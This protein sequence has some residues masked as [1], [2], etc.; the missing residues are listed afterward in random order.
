[1]AK[2]IIP[3]IM[4]FIII[5]SFFSDSHA[6]ES[7]FGYQPLH[8][9]IHYKE[10]FFRLYN[11][12]LY[13]ELDSVSR[14]IFFLELAY[15][16]PFDHPIKALTPITNDVQYERYRNLLMTHICTLLTQ[17]YINYGY[18]YMK[19]H[20]YF[21]NSDFKDEYLEGY[22]IA[23]FYF[24]Q[25]KKYWDQAIQYGQAA[26]NI[27]GFRTDLEAMEDEIYRMKTGNLN[28]YKV[29]DN[30]MMR[31]NRNRSEIESLQGK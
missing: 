3:I 7:D 1:M 6:A 14:N 22:D 29:I 27:N 9:K 13:S 16:V 23:E 17:E 30:L 12:W 11:Q 25:A 19:E 10:D 18:M 28:Y 26:D 4:V 21:F 15:S 2:I 5:S 24:N 8:Q 20:I 31:I